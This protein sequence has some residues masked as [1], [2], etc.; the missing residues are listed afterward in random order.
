MTYNKPSGVDHPPLVVPGS[1]A[2]CC[3]LPPEGEVVEVE[4]SELHA[5]TAL[6]DRLC[7]G[8]QGDLAILGGTR[9]SSMHRSFLTVPASVLLAS[10]SAGHMSRE[11]S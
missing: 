10:K 6:D 1:Q 4:A 9:W 3:H 11:S 7:P 8:I 2:R 5:L